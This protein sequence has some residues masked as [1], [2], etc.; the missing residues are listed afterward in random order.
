MGYSPDERFFSTLF[1]LTHPLR[2][3]RKV[4]YRPN[5]WITFDGDK[6]VLFAKAKKKNKG[7]GDPRGKMKEIFTVKMI[8]FV[9]A[10]PSSA[11][12]KVKPRA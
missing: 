7:G 2:A 5:S 11:K 4:R 9:R 8:Y 6:R 1:E 3:T 12:V 10:A